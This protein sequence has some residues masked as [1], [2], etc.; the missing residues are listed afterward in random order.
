MYICCSV[1]IGREWWCQKTEGSP[2]SS[3]CSQ[4]S[5]K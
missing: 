3:I 4:E 5:Q 1:L 2:A